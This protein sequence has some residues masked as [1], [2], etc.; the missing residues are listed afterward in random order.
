MTPADEKTLWTA[1][2]IVALGAAVVLF[3]AM[4]GSDTGNSSGYSE[5]RPRMKPDEVIRRFNEAQAKPRTFEQEWE[6]QKRY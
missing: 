4:F 5:E 6:R 2:V 3:M 1:A